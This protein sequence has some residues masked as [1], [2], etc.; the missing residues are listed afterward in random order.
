MDTKEQR[1]Q[2][3]RDV[4]RIIRLETEDDF[5]LAQWETDGGAS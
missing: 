1:E 4:Q 2:R 3:D 5:A